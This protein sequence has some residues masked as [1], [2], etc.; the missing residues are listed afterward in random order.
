MKQVTKLSGKQCITDKNRAVS[1]MGSLLS[2][3][4]HGRICL[5]DCSKAERVFRNGEVG[6]TATSSFYVV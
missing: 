4:W 5:A 2:S 6:T 1:A 3:E